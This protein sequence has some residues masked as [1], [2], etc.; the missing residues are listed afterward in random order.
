MEQTYVKLEREDQI[1]EWVTTV[2]VRLGKCPG[3]RREVQARGGFVQVRTS[4]Q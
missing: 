4:V 3:E 2:R 1:S